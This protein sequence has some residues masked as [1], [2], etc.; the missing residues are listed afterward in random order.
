MRDLCEGCRFFNSYGDGGECRRHAP[1]GMREQHPELAKWPW[2]NA[3]GWCGDFEAR[4]PKES[5]EISNV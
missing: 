4:P 5:K 3:H 2:V 1:I